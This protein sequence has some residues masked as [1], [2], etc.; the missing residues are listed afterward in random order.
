MTAVAPTFLALARSPRDGALRVVHDGRLP[1]A[2]LLVAFATVISTAH[3]IR[4][5]SEVAVEDVVF[6]RE[7]SPV[8]DAL[9]ATLGRDLTS[10]VVYLI[11]R[12]WDALLVASALS[13]ALIWI[14]GATA[15]HAAARLG[16]GSRPFLPM[17]VLVGY[18]TGLT[19]PAADLAGLLFGSRGPLGTVAQ[20]AATAALVWLGVLLWHGIRAH[21]G[22]AGG[23]A[24]TILVLAIVLFYLAPITLVLVAV[25]AVLVAAVVLE[26]FPVR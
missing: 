25:T 14:L 21:Y 1:M 3:A 20:V 19:R 26:Y 23:Q 10:V 15:I 22:V 17:L 6:G 4:Y 9:L 11:Q 5:S 12:A 18:A 2:L 8:I 13:P 24:V 16:G 7:R